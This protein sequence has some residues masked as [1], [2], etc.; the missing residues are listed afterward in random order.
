MFGISWGGFNSLH[1]AMRK[2][3]ALKAI[4]SLMSTDDLYEDDVHYID[5]MMHVDAY[6][7]GQDLANAMP[8]APDFVIDD[9][10]F[11]DRFETTPWMLIYKQQ[12][13]DG[14][15]WNRASLN[16]DYS[17]LQVP[18]FLIGGWYDGYRDAPP[19]ILQHAKVPVKAMIGPWNHTFPSDADPPPAIEWRQDAVRWFDYWLKGIQNGITEEPRFSAF[20]RDYHEPG[21]SLAA[22]PGDWYE[23]N[24]WPTAQHDSTL[25]FQSTHRLGALP[26]ASGV[27]ELTYKPSAGIDA[28]GSVMWWGDWAPDQ[29]STDST[30]L[31][32]DSELVSRDVPIMGFPKVQLRVSATAPLAY[33]I[34]RLSDV[35]PDGK[36][37]QIT[38][39]GFNG[40]HRYSSERPTAIVRNEILQLDIDLHFTSWTFRKGH[41]IRI[42]VSNAQWPMI[43]PT[44]DVMTTSL[45]FPQS[46]LMLPIL[47]T[48]KLSKTSFSLPEQSVDLPGYE[49][50]D[51]T[52]NSGF[53][54]LSGVKRDEKNKRVTVTATNSGAERFPWGR[55]ISS[56]RIEHEV[57]DET[58]WRTSVNSTYQTKVELSNRTLIWEGVLHFSSD[59][60]HFYY[61]YTRNLYESEKL[62]RSKTWKKKIRRDFH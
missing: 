59:K 38:G 51:A 41:R 53:A 13:R 40:T 6:E 47:E 20:V 52:T 37:T 25:Y 56:E 27:H 22:I 33:W 3:P 62:I 57:Y 29:R 43:W 23:L 28:G 24:S 11:K 4:V 5:G 35:A 17:K 31:V 44:P 9:H 21:S 1:L 30:C 36:V 61:V 34:V 14:A 8:G 50:I 39:A 12:Q 45:R 10:Y 46:K 7:I 48:N 16:T 15:F 49:S 26:A 18:A 54:E 42:A 2:P 19:K 32:Y 55:Y 58:P 60:K